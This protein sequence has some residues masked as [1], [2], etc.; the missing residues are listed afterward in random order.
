MKLSVSSLTSSYAVFL[1]IFPEEFKPPFFVDDLVL[2]IQV[3]KY[4]ILHSPVVEEFRRI[5]G[6]SVTRT[7]RTEN[8]TR[9][10]GPSVWLGARGNKKLR[11]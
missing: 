4:C 8:Y 2:E 1:E 5:D 10:V 9:S 6:Y 7:V 3:E 11:K